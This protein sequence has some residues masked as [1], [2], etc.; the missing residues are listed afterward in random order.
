MRL[1][2][3]YIYYHLSVISLHTI[4]SIIRMMSHVHGCNYW[5]YAMPLTAYII[6]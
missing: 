3:I 1:K 4:I 5:V 6:E 2:Q